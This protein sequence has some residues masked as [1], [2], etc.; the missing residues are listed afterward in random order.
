MRLDIAIAAA[1]ACSSIPWQTRDVQLVA[2]GRQRASTVSRGD[3][4]GEL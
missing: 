3:R 4:D 1:T 2:L